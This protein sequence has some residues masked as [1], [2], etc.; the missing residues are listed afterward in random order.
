MPIKK[1]QRTVRADDNPQVKLNKIFS[2]I[3]KVK[4][5]WEYT[6]T[7]K[8]GTG[9]PQ[10]YFHRKEWRGNRLV[11]F[12]VHGNLPADKFICHTCDNKACLNPDHLYAGTPRQNLL[13]AVRNGKNAQANQTHCKRGHE[14]TLENTRRD[15]Y[16]RR[17]CRTCIKLFQPEYD[18]KYREK[19]R[20]ERTVIKTD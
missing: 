8:T 9:Y 19:K 15:K 17:C 3:Q 6:G 14:F 2:R 1:G 7:L 16:G 12:L 5:C 11:Y 13:D 18:R 10:I 20:A 4:G